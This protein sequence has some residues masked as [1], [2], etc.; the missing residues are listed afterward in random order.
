MLKEQSAKMKARVQ[1]GGG[2]L[3]SLRERLL[4]KFDT[5]KDGRLDD[6]ERAAAQKFAAEHG[7]TP[8]GE[9]RAELFARFDR[10]KDGTLD[11]T[12]RRAMIAFMA[13]KLQQPPFVSPVA[14]QTQELEKVLRAAI[15]ADAVQLKRY[16][17]N[18]NGRLDDAEWL[19]IKQR[20]TGTPARAEAGPEAE[21]RRLEAVAAEVARRRKLREDSGGPTPPKP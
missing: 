21:R 1:L 20:L 15:V 19:A 8:E 6:E 4:E 12:E 17:T 9:M 11:E 10:D 13:E 18:A 3:A 7:F 16:D 2:S 14:E 5:N